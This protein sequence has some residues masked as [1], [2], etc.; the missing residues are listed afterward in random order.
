MRKT[1]KVIGFSLIFISMIVIAYFWFRS[2]TYYD[3]YLLSTMPDDYVI[4]R[5]SNQPISVKELNSKLENKG[6]FKNKGT[7]F[8]EFGRKYGVDPILVTA[9]ALFETGKGTSNVVKKYNNP[10]GLMDPKNPMEFQQ[11]DTLEE[12]IEAMTSNLYRNYISKGLE[13][14][15]EIA[16]IYAPVGADNDIHDTN[17]NWAPNV[18]KFINYLGGL[19]KHCDTK[20]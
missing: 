9:I 4:C 12:G 7:A 2:S 6:V 1:S 20:K 15:K 8:I 17:S 3:N 16:P 14:P 11:F 19:E 10:G 5:P 18:T 13:L